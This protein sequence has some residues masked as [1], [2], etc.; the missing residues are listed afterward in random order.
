MVQ[1]GADAKA[2]GEPAG[3]LGGTDV[4]ADMAAK[5]R[6]VDAE[7]ADAFRHLMPGMVAKEQHGTLARPFHH[8]D[9]AGVVRS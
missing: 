6:L 5:L 9:E 7:M 8:L 3:H 4:P 1:D 2:L